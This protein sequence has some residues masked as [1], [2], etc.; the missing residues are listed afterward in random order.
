MII[1]T[2]TKVEIYKEL[3][4]YS[5]LISPKHKGRGNCDFIFLAKN[6]GTNI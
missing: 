5:F 1:P 3:E 6:I 2:W 4:D